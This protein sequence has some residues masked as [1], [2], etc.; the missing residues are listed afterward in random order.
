MKPYGLVAIVLRALKP[1]DK[2]KLIALS[3]F[4]QE[5]VLGVHFTA[6]LVF[7]GDHS[8]GKLN[9]HNVRVRGTNIS[10][11]IS[12]TQVYSLFFFVFEHPV[13]GY[14]LV[15]ECFKPGYFHD[16]SRRFWL[17]QPMKLYV[18]FVSLPRIVLE[19]KNENTRAFSIEWSIPNERVLSNHGVGV[20]F[21]RV[22]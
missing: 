16:S 14:D 11:A 12:K 4:I 21:V 5:T 9:R 13:N 7:S 10:R 6:R 22:P 2:L 3:V 19:I 17:L 18:F 1:T 15:W 20:A 8:S